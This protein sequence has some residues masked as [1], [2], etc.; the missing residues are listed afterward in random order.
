M[1][2]WNGKFGLQILSLCGSAHNCLSRSVPGTHLHVAGLL[3]NQERTVSQLRLLD[4]ALVTQTEKGKGEQRGQRGRGGKRGGM[5]V[6]W[7]L[8]LRPSNRLVYLRDGSAQTILRA[9]T[10]R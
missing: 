2:V 4:V 8:A 1:I 3:C 9:A 5:F 6:G 7:L 10:L